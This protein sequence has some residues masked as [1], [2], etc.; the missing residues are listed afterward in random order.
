AS[1]ASVPSIA[2]T[3]V[4]AAASAPAAVRGERDEHDAPPQRAVAPAPA[5]KTAAAPAA[6]PQLATAGADDWETF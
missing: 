2:S 5:R 3:V 4:R 1:A 6:A